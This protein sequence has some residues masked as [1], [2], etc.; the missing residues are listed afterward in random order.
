MSYPKNHNLPH[1]NDAAAGIEVTEDFERFTQRNDV[2]T[3]AF[4]DDTVR[5]NDT[6]LRSLIL[7]MDREL[8]RKRKM[9]AKIAARNLKKAAKAAAK[10]KAAAD[11]S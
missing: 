7:N 10:A 3:R 11:E 8:R 4:W 1:P 6:V 9:D 5:T 2:F